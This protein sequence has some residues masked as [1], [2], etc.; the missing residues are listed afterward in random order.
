MRK[1][2]HEQFV[3]EVLNIVGHEKYEFLT[4][5]QGCDKK[6]TIK[7]KEDA[8]SWSI[9]ANGFLNNGCHCPKCNNKVMNKDTDYFKTQLKE[10]YED[11]YIF[12]H[13]LCLINIVVS[14][15]MYS[16]RT[17]YSS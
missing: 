13:L 17:V 5:Y 11:E 7:C 10:L 6:I 8:Y 2:T 9:Q 4:E 14:V 15:L 1:R 12:P 16:P 3:E